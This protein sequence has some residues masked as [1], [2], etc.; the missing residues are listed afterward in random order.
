MAPRRDRRHDVARFSGHVPKDWATDRERQFVPEPDVVQK[1]GISKQ[2]VQIGFYHEEKK[3]VMQGLHPTAAILVRIY[4]GR[5]RLRVVESSV[6]VH[7]HPRY[8]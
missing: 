6:L 1:A 7:N 8:R 4:P 2:H 3:R 5:S